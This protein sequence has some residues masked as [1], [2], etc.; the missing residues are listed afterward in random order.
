MLPPESVSGESVTVGGVE[1][2]VWWEMEE[3]QATAKAAIEGFVPLRA[4]ACDAPMEHDGVWVAWRK[5]GR[6]VRLRSGPMPTLGAMKLRRRWGTRLS[7]IRIV[8]D[9]ER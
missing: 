9:I 6:S 8:E 4:S 1:E 2:R 7:K 3:E 5:C